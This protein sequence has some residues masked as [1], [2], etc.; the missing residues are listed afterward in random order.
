MRVTSQAADVMEVTLPPMSAEEIARR[1][2]W[3]AE[4]E[5]ME[6][7]QQATGLPGTRSLA[8]LM[9]DAGWTVDCYARVA[10]IAEQALRAGGYL[11]ASTRTRTQASRMLGW[12][13]LIQ[14]AVENG[15]PLDSAFRWAGVLAEET[16]MRAAQALYRSIEQW[17]G[18]VAEWEQAGLGDVGRLAF[19]AGLTP[20]EV[21][22]HPGYSVADLERLRTLARLRGSVAPRRAW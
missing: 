16:D 12:A 8:R 9:L 11:A 3:R 13:I 21:R 2:A 17:N 14:C 7:R 18:V 15:A 4:Q 20:E 1:D 19:Q 22:A 6:E 10:E 5:F